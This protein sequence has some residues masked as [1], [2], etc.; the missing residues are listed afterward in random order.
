MTTEQ[1]VGVTQDD[2]S[3]GAAVFFSPASLALQ[4]VANDL[5]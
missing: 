1:L 3:W 4:Y 5:Q 2:D